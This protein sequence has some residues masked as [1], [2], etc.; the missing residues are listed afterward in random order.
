M[1]KQPILS[2]DCLRKKL[3]LVTFRHC[4]AV[5]GVEDLKVRFGLFE[6]RSERRRQSSDVNL[7]RILSRCSGPFDCGAQ[8]ESVC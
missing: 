8:S 7:S 6:S 2:R 4:S 1:G 5:S 3:S